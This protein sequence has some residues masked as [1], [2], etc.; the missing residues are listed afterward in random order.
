MYG[1]FGQKYTGK[2]TIYS[3]IIYT[4]YKNIQVRFL[5]SELNNF[6]YTEAKISYYIS[7]RNRTF[8]SVSQIALF[9]NQLRE[10]GLDLNNMRFIKND[11][12]CSN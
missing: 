6:W 7:I 4:D 8:D 2:T 9:I 1:F 10:L 5:C 11:L 3:T 12:S